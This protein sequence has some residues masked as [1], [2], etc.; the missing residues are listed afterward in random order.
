M[1]TKLSTI[2]TLV[3]NKKWSRRLKRK[4]ISFKRKNTRKKVKTELTTVLTT[5]SMR[6]L[7]TRK[8]KN[9]KKTNAT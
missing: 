6:M 7:Q 1:T 5:F 3:Y 2:L 4:M 9:L 8:K